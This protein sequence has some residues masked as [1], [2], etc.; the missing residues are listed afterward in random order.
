MKKDC[1]LVWHFIESR[2]WHR[3]TGGG[4]YEMHMWK[5]LETWHGSPALLFHMVGS[6][7]RFHIGL[8]VRLRMTGGGFAL[9]PCVVRGFFF[10]SQPTRFG[11]VKQQLHHPGCFHPIFTFLLTLTFTLL[12]LSDF[13]CCCLENLSYQ[14][15]K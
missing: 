8:G 3:R 6:P 4:N 2:S 7:A 11:D 1:G 15:E 12:Q 10:A 9:Q 5:Q 14:L 13:N